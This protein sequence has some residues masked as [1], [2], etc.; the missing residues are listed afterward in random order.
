MSD[1]GALGESRARDGVG[2]GGDGH[3]GRTEVELP[4]DYLTTGSSRVA[5]A[6]RLFDV[7]DALRTST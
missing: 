2:L 4:D 6:K 1:P 5:K 3:R 7:A